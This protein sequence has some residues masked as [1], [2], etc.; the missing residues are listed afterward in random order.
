MVGGVGRWPGH[1]CYAEEAE[2]VGVDLDFSGGSGSGQNA[3][4]VCGVVVDNLRYVVVLRVSEYVPGD[5]GVGTQ[6]N[7]G[8]AGAVLDG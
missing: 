6:Q 7:D 4:G 8:K 5:G 3:R 2:L 1:G